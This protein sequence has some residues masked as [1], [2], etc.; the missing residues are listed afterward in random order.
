M[1]K[2]IFIKTTFRGF[3]KK[4]VMDYIEQMQQENVDLKAKVTELEQALA[5]SKEEAVAKE[6]RY[7]AA[8]LDIKNAAIEAMAQMKA[9]QEAESVFQDLPQELKAANVEFMSG[10]PVDYEVTME[11]LSPSLDPVES[12]E[13]DDLNEALEAYLQEDHVAEL[14]GDEETLPDP[15]A[16]LADETVLNTESGIKRVK[17][18]LKK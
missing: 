10:N 15:L 6:E 1:E 16:Q 17:V 5:S 13:D 18:K 8:V 11:D 3:D 9:E 7:K 12:S 14:L 2:D 4:A